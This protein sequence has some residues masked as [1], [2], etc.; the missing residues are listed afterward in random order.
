MKK[1]Y[2]ITVFANAVSLS[3]SNG[4][5]AA[6]KHTQN[7]SPRAVSL[8][9]TTCCCGYILV[10]GFLL[11]ILCLRSAIKKHRSM[12]HSTFSLARSLIHSLSL[13]LCHVGMV[14]FTTTENP[15]QI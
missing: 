12:T 8:S 3:Q 2:I 14:V 9:A 10:E 13:Y 5:I 1:A 7:Y 4:P 15:Q 6:K 11:Y